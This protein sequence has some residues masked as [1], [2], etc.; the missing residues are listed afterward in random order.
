MSMTFFLRAR[1]VAF[2][3]G[4]CDSHLDTPA[5]SAHGSATPQTV[6][7]AVADDVDNAPE[8]LGR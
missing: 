2:L 7:A 3:V 1:T 8:A 4:S 6:K 5:N